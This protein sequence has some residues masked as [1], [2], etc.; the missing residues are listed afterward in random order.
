MIH[1][2]W[3]GLAGGIAERGVSE[4]SAEGA[5]I[6]PGIGPCCF[7]VGPEVAA[8]FSDLGGGIAEGRML[9]VPEVCERI[10]RR[11]GVQHVERSGLC[12][13]CES[14]LFFSHRRDDG[15]TGRQAG[16]VWRCPS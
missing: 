15:I 1:C 4:V 7:E 12:T 16:L 11:A 3:R 5:V 13:Y 2:G 14:G 9:D 10:L 8:E 6:G